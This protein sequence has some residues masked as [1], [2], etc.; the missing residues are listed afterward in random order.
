MKIISKTEY[1]LLLTDNYLDDLITRLPPGGRL[2]GIR[3]MILQSGAGRVFLERKLRTMLENGVIEVKNRQGY[4][5]K[6]VHSVPQ[7]LYLHEAFYPA[8]HPGF[9]DILFASCREIARQRGYEMKIVKISGMDESS[10]LAILKNSDARMVFLVGQPDASRAAFVRKH[11]RYCMEVLPRH[12]VTQ[13]SE[14]RN[15]STT[16]LQ[17]EYLFKRK[18]TRIAY[19]HQVENWNNTPTQLMRLLDY[20]RMM[21]EKHLPVYPDWVF[22]YNYEWESFKCSMYKM[23]N[24]DHP[25]EVVI[26]PGCCMEHFYDFCSHNGI[27]IGRELAVMGCDD[28]SPEL[29]PRPTSVTNYPEVVARQ[30]WQIMDSLVAGVVLHEETHLGIVTGET[31]PVCTAENI[32]GGDNK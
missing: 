21:S 4:Y 3:T 2:P 31:V 10:L 20:Y 18:Y 9:N 5:K 8:R 13:G 25:P 6:T 26:V 17:M 16:P 24:S 12:A 19:I 1:K 23:L 28:L 27:N 7:V 15:A 22:Q 11:V 14:L 29:S 32:S 30:V